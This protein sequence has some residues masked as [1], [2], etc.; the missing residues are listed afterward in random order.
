[1]QSLRLVGPGEDGTAVVLET[2][3]G[4]QRFTLPLDERLRNVSQDQT[5]EPPAAEPASAAHPLSPREIQTRVRAGESAQTVAEAAGMPIEKVM[6][7]ALPV[8][9]ERTRV[10]EEAKRA[11][12][13]RPGESGS[14]PFGELI[15]ERLGRHGVDPNGVDWDAYRRPDGGWTVTASFTAQEQGRQAKFSFGL[16]NRTVSA[17]DALA[18]DLLS[19]RP[20]RALLPPDPEPVAE[21]V[22]PG[23]VRL[24]AVPDRPEVEPDESG[25]EELGL[26]TPAVRPF[27]RQKAHTRP[28]P[29]DSDDELFDQ[30]A[31]DGSAGGWHEPAL[32][33]ELAEPGYQPGTE[34]GDEPGYEPGEGRHRRSRRGDKPRMP[35]WDDILLG[36]RHKE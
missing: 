26:A 10:V 32:P 25:T 30:E 20:V 3:D 8:L 4:S 2:L 23:P 9:A 12:A 1:M 28:I 5:P 34:A 29:V 16:G 21:L 7:F 18:A 13:R 22:E 35:S 19:D 11:R 31:F 6:R 33:L 24:S 15:A 36:V 17:L 14:A 27:R